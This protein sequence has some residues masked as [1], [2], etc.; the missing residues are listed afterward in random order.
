M[1]PVTPVTA[2]ATSG[3]ALNA[4]DGMVDWA[5]GVAVQT[6]WT[7]SGSLPQSVTV[8]LGA[9]YS[10][11][12]TL[13]YLPRQD[14]DSSGN[15]VTTGNITGYRVLTSTDGSNFTAVTSGTW[16]VDKT[17]KRARFS[18]VNARYIRLEATAASNGSPVV[19]EI[20]VGGTAAR[21][22]AGG[23]TTSSSASS[24]SATSSSP[25]PTTPSSTTPSSS[26]S[27]VGTLTASYK[28]TGS[29]QGGFQGEV[30]V[31]AG[32]AAISGWTVAWT[33]ASGQSITQVWNGTLTTSGSSVTV[34][35]A[36]WNGALPAN[37]STTF[38]F[39]CSGSPSTPTLT[40]TSP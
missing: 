14:K 38:G 36:S 8:D 22:V 7:A 2:T 33:L 23:T 4:I 19:S 39:I 3:T 1:H 40:P 25:Q 21:P 13:H 15:M 26:A 31:T 35:N 24:P 28:T 10:N 18:A 34:K 9:N 20:S 37:G 16:A 32:N 12:D 17:L 29:W 5:G 11:I 27:L 30:T 6:L